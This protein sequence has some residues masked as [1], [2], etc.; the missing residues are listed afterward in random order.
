MEIELHNLGNDYYKLGD[1]ERAVE[2]YTK[3]LEIRP[4]MLESY[5]N[6]ALAHTKL[7]NFEKAIDDHTQAISL[8]PGLIEAYFTR[9]LV[10]EYMKEYDEAIGDYRRVLDIKPDYREVREQLQIAIRKKASL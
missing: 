1:Y 3:A 10:H 4:D 2:H 8:D 5:F 9:G 6:R 7:H